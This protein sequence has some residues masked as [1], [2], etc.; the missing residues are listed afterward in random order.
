[1]LLSQPETGKHLPSDAVKLSRKCDSARYLGVVELTYAVPPESKFATASGVHHFKK[2]VA[3]FMAFAKRRADQL[4]SS[5][6]AKRKRNLVD[7]IVLQSQSAI[8]ILDAERRIRCFSPGL[9]SLTGWAAADVEG[10]VCSPTSSSEST[11]I[12]LLTMALYPSIS[13]LEGKLQ[14]AVTVVPSKR[15]PSIRMH[16][17][18]VPILD[19]EGS[20]QR[21]IVMC[22]PNS[23]QTA[24]PSMA[25]QL[26]AEITALRID[27]RRRFS[28]QSF[29]GK[30]S[31]IQRALQQAELL[32]S[33]SCGYY[34]CGPS[35]SGRR[36]LAKT[37]HISGQQDEESFVPMDCRLLTA[38]QI[39]ATLQTLKQLREQDI[40]SHQ[41]AGTL[42]LV[43]ADRCP[44]EVQTWIL[45]KQTEHFNDVR[46]AATSQVPLEQ[47]VEEGWMLP[48]FFER[49]NPVV[50]NLPS[51]HTRSEDIALLSHHFVLESKR[52]QETSAESISPELLS[53][54]E[55]YR[56]P[57]NVRELETVIRQACENSFEDEL[58]VSD[59]PFS[60]VAGVDAQRMPPLPEGGEQSLEAILRKFEIDVLQ[61]T[62]NACRD[63]KA[64]AARRLGLTR[65]KLYRR[66]KALGMDTDEV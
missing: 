11:T 23:S 46:L 56:W 53:E 7:A 64:E 22:D 3:A 20:V 59:L 15:G 65:P 9:E 63:N 2:F 49:L 58:E 45:E 29:V 30:S 8:C 26:H 10:L 55:F 37:I 50:I 52:L 41:N 34:I 27:F 39:V 32:K 17:T 18:Y 24:A 4:Q 14:S 57:G 43:D 40:A 48:D 28:S 51:L 1:M 21:V 66:L 12:D 47:V 33:S 19:N 25:Q 36:H 16:L 38:D 42:L 54:L 60:F 44:R 13:V 35:G 5:A 6:M 61:K 31:E 62:L